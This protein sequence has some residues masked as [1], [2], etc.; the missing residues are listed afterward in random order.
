LNKV[1]SSCPGSPIKR[2]IWRRLLVPDD[3]LLGDLH[4]VWVAAMGWGGYHMHAFRFGGGFNP[5]EYS[6]HQMAIEC[7]SRV[8]DENEVLLSALIRRPGQTFSYEYDF[9]DSWQHEVK[10]EKILPYDPSV[11]LPVCLAGARAC[12]PEDCGSYPGYANVLRVLQKPDPHREGID[13]IRTKDGQLRHPLQHRCYES[14]FKFRQS[15]K[16][17]G[18]EVAEDP[19][20]AES[21]FEFM[22]TSVKLGGALDGMARGDGY[23]DNAFTVALL[24][25]ALGRLQQ[26][27]AAL[28]TAGTKKLLPNRLITDVRDEMFVIR[29]ELIRLMEDLRRRQ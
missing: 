15:V 10:V 11:A 23:H 16:E 4:P 18:T 27:Q 19:V 25:R 26:A 28:E 29:E 9:G 22:R 5:T 17:L 24:K 13:W 14:A 12:P 2:P 20:V 21:V 7:G 1:I 3:W 6:T 8:Q